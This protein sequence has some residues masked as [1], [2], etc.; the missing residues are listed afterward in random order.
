MIWHPLQAFHSKKIKKKRR[1]KKEQKKNE[2][3]TNTHSWEGEEKRKNTATNEEETQGFQMLKGFRIE[4]SPLSPPYAGFPISTASTP[5]PQKRSL[6]QPTDKIKT[7]N[8][9]W[10]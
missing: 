6:K 7:I 10:Y 4:R 9:Y 8:S 5:P 3:N 2:K 1:D